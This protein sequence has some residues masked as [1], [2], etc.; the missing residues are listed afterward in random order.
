MP[1]G[2]KRMREKSDE[3]SAL[4]IIIFMDMLQEVSQPFLLSLNDIVKY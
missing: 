3:V 4:V 1:L 2:L